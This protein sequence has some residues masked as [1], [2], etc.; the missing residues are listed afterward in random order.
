M[1]LFFFFPSLDAVQGLIDDWD[2]RETKTTSESPPYK[3]F[4]RWFVHTLGVGVAAMGEVCACG[5]SVNED[6]VEA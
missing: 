6:G 5:L 2:E 4:A 1:Y 3:Y